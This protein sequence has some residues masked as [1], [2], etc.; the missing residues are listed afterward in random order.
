MPA[1]GITPSFSARFEHPLERLPRADRVGRAVGVD[2]LAGEEGH[3]AVPGHVAQ[4][5]EVEPRQRVGKAVLP[6]GDLRVVVAQVVRVPAEDDVAEAEAALRRAE[7]LVAVQVLAA[8]DAVDVADRDLDLADA[9]LADR[10]D[11]G[12]FLLAGHVL[13]L[14]RGRGRRWECPSPEA[15][16]RRR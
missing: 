3:A 5:V 6:A 9:R 1:I 4:R 16:R 14:L 2:E 8:Q 11:R 12:V 13:V 7:E 15:C 10:G